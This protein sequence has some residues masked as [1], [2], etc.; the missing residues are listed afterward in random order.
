MLQN[1]AAPR[2][3]FRQKLT[4]AAFSTS[5]CLAPFVGAFLGGQKK[6]LPFNL[7]FLTKEDGVTSSEM[8]D[9]SSCWSHDIKMKK[10]YS[11]QNTGIILSF[12]YTKDASS[13][14]T[15]RQLCPCTTEGATYAVTSIRLGSTTKY[16]C[17]NLPAPGIKQQ[18]CCWSTVLLLL[19]IHQLFSGCYQ[20]K[21]A[22]PVSF[23]IHYF[24]LELCYNV[25]SKSF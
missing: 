24:R 16:N 10:M 3:M 14:Y 9:F 4:V 11:K 21:F 12:Y 20:N 5:I 22:L 18:Y 25:H 7:L 23:T 17:L 1:K 8:T 15:S 13:T 19:K 2:D 6:K